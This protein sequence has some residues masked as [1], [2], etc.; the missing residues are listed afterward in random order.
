MAFKFR[1]QKIL[2]LK[3]Q[4][5]DVLKKELTDLLNKKK[6]LLHKKNS[7]AKEKDKNL[8]ALENN[9]STLFII[10]EILAYFSFIE[11]LDKK[12]EEILEFLKILEKEIIQAR[13]KLIQASKEK[14]VLIK[15]KE[16]K[17][18]IYNQLENRREQKFFDEIAGIRD[19]AKKR[20]SKGNL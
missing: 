11:V 15:L 13:E 5:E 4:K 14:K 19:I 9:L 16:K 6:E 10:E 1:L 7:L 17:E 12:I 2:E 3:K 20:A 18:K 8:Y